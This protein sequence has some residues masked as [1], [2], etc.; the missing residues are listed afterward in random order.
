MTTTDTPFKKLAA[1]NAAILKLRDKR[2]NL[3][4]QIEIYQN[5]LTKID[6]DLSQSETELDAIQTLLG[7]YETLEREHLTI[8]VEM[9]KILER[10]NAK[11]NADLA[12]GT[13]NPSDRKWEDTVE[14]S[15]H[16]VLKARKVEI[17]GRMAEITKAVN[18]VYY[19]R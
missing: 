3:V 11:D 6:E 15:D 1:K 14:G 13:Y 9:N 4:G 2:K 18:K 10:I 7:E 16:P 5:S 12:A 17:E 8:S 19:R